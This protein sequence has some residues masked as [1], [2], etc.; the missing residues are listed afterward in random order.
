MV[1]VWIKV[2]VAPFTVS[3]GELGGLP[4]SRGALILRRKQ[5]FRIMTCEAWIA[6]QDIKGEVGQKMVQ[7]RGET[8]RVGHLAHCLCCE[9]RI[10]MFPATHTIVL[11]N[12]LRHNPG[13]ENGRDCSQAV[14]T[15]YCFC[16]VLLQLRAFF[17]IFELGL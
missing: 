11:C 7:E 2:L 5:R 6:E 16:N 4:L 1:S 17:V 10:V 15:L 8:H 9:T 3:P 12:P 13:V 14:D